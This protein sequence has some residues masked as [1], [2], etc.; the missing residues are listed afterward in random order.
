MFKGTPRIGTAD[1]EKDRDLLARIDVAWEES[2]RAKGGA[3]ASARRRFEDLVEEERRYV[4]KDELWAT[5]QA[6]GATGLNAFTSQDATVYL[7][8]LPSN[9]LEL[10]FWLESDRMRNSVFREFYSEREVVKEERRLRTVNAPAGP[11]R[12]QLNALAFSS[13]PYRWPVVGWMSDLDAITRDDMRAFYEAYYTPRNAVL[14]LVGDLDPDAC[15]ELAE[16]YFGGIPSGPEPPAV[17]T[18]EPPQRGRKTYET[19]ARAAPRATVL[20]HTPAWDH[21]DTAA[22]EVLSGV[23]S[24]ENGRLH[25]RLVREL[26]LA[27]SAWAGA[28]AQRYPDLFTVSARAAGDTDPA[29]LLPAIEM[30]VRALQNVEVPAAELARVKNRLV[31]SRLRRLR[32]NGAIGVMLPMAEIR[33]DWRFVLDFPAKIQA[34]TAADVKRVA[35]RHL[36][37]ESSTVGLLRREEKGGAK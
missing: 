25:R 6:A 9:R 20:W 29:E 18:V 24:G 13:H 3:A 33:G 15:L 26:S 35:K 19:T 5:Y 27:L 30:E 28:S 10:F 17:A 34:V 32:R 16:R 14:C 36:T 7:V 8:T 1:W 23:L 11:F 22:L 4:K 37:R 21:P 31:A 2:S 12:E